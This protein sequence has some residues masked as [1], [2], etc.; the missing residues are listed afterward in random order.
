MKNCDD[1]MKC[2]SANDVTCEECKRLSLQDKRN[3]IESMIQ[4]GSEA[5][6]F[7]LNREKNLIKL[8]FPTDLLELY[9]LSVEEMDELR[10]ELAAGKIDYEKIK[11]EAADA[12]AY[13]FKI[14]EVCGRMK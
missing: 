9:F 12:C 14:I 5:M 8:S 10:D 2:P 4:L 11:Y 1:S 7:V 6:R 3:E 13:L